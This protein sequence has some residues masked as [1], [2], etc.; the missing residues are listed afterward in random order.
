M[1]LMKVCASPG[2]RER[3]PLGQRYCEEHQRLASKREARQKAE[4]DDKRRQTKGDSSKRGYGYRW[5]SARA[6]FLLEHPLC[7][8]CLKN[9]KV[10]QATDVDHIKPHRGDVNLFWDQSNWQPL[11][12]ACHSR[13][14]AKEDGGFGNQYRQLIV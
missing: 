7:V 12:H 11:C 2:C 5:R 1:S 10:E 13:K 8:E 3:I 14:T 6:A 4:R 9:G